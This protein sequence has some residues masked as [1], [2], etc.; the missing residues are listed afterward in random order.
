MLDVLVIAALGFGEGPAAT[1]RIEL[2][3]SA[4]SGC[5]GHDE[6]TDAAERLL[7]ASDGKVQAVASVVE[8]ADGRFELT[9]EAST[10]TTVTRHVHV[11]ETCE[12]LGEVAALFVA[13][14]ADPAA[15]VDRI[16]IP[17]TDEPPKSPERIASP[18]TVIAE[19]TIESAKPT[20]RDGGWIR[21]HAIVGAAQLP[22]LD[23]GLG[24][25]GGWSR[26]RV[27]LVASIAH[28]FGRERAVPGLDPAHG[29]L[30]AWNG[31]LHGCI[32][33]GRRR[34]RGGGCAGPE[35]GAVAA[36]SRE[37][38]RPGKSVG[39]WVAASAGPIVRWRPTGRVQIHAGVEGVVALRRPTF[40]LRDD[41]RATVGAGQGG[42]R[43]VLGIAIGLGAERRDQ[44]GRQWR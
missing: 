32:E 33:L 15:V 22:G 18:P 12:R 29:V 16:A 37:V 36:R 38:D 25:A 6:V 8:R 42:V 19:R 7:L 40:A 26:G 5:P 35:L 17:V 10:P 30:S 24:M 27:A 14:A 28:L 43:A 20:K 39:L 21:V 44:N 34:W 11:A 41:V 13:V 3:W 9:V 1:E 31:T 4:P 2:D 23:A